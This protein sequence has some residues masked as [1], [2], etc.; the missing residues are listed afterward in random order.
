MPPGRPRKS[1]P[2]EASPVLSKS[3]SPPPLIKENGDTPPKKRKKGARSKHRKQSPSSPPPIIYIFDLDVIVCGR[4]KFLRDNHD[5][6]DPI[7]NTTFTGS[8][9]M[10]DWKNHCL[11]VH[12]LLARPE[13]YS[14][15]FKVK[16]QIQAWTKS[17]E[18]RGTLVCDVCGHENRT[19]PAFKYHNKTHH[20]SSSTGTTVSKQQCQYFISPD[21]TFNR[22]RASR[23]QISYPVDGDDEE[24]TPNTKKKRSKAE[25]DEEFRLP[26]SERKKVTLIRNVVG[27]EKPGAASTSGGSTEAH[28]ALPCAYVIFESGAAV[29]WK[30][31]SGHTHVDA[32]RH[33]ALHVK[34]NHSSK[35]LFCEIDCPAKSIG[36][37]V[38]RDDDA[39]DYLPPQGESVRI[40]AS[41]EDPGMR[42]PAMEGAVDSSGSPLLFAGGS[43]TAFSWIPMSSLTGPR[44][45][46]LSTLADFEACYAQTGTRRE[47]G[48]V[49]IWEVDLE[50]IF[51]LPKPAKE[52]SKPKFCFGIALESAP[53]WSLSTLPS[54]GEMEAR[55]G[56][57]PRATLLAAAC[58]SGAVLVFAV[59]MPAQIPSKCRGKLLKLQP[60]FSF[61]LAPG[62]PRSQV[63]SLDWNP[64]SPHSILGAGFNN[65]MVALWDM[66]STSPLLRPRN[67]EGISSWPSASHTRYP[68]STF[69]AHSETVSALS[70]CPS[71]LGAHLATVSLD[72]R[73]AVWTVASVEGGAPLV[74]SPLLTLQHQRATWPR[75]VTWM[76][77]WPFLEIAE[78]AIGNVHSGTG[79]LGVTN[80]DSDFHSWCNTPAG[81]QSV[82]FSPWL[83]TSLTCSPPFVSLTLHRP[84]RVAFPDEKAARKKRYNIAK[85]TLQPLS[86][87]EG[88]GLAPSYS[89]TWEKYGLRVTNCGDFSK[90]KFFRGPQAF[91]ATSNSEGLHLGKFPL[92][93]ATVVAFCPEL[94]RCTWFAMAGYSGIV[95][96]TRLTGIEEGLGVFIR[97]TEKIL[98]E[99]SQEA[100]TPADDSTGR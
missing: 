14:Q 47:K 94:T 26:P 66:T 60:K 43:V 16:E 17:L 44:V 7:E 98:E 69:Q 96:F 76:G 6:K 50:D 51:S 64:I 91:V 11:Y 85:V 37:S 95:R 46:A 45:M 42:I 87:E 39:R 13:G 57:L 34:Q 48:C 89:M 88:S 86:T 90:G 77:I 55:K 30:D 21:D 78:E 8:N 93:V 32:M 23:K 38:L 82:T 68:F 72:K 9:K 10:E 67:G 28:E 74:V 61:E 63:T 83:N 58:A 5:F 18:I 59:P 100:G 20:G 54:G 73:I 56:S 92:H 70:F 52:V 1:I 84:L 12:N 33:Y 62:L 15:D 41:R 19:V 36:S 49:Q 25:K 53:V 2:Q 29:N 75:D 97:A 24:A 35:P 81:A 27:E 3:E 80:Y 22:K 99:E 31:H 71:T 40:F 4:C 65:G 79:T